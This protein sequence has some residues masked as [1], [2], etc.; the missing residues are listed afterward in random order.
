MLQ[1]N[2]SPVSQQSLRDANISIILIIH[3][4][5]KVFALIKKIL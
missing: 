2:K 1:N 5:K 3:M 4:V